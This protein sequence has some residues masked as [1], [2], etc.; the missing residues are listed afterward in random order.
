[1]R[2]VISRTVDRVLHTTSQVELPVDPEAAAFHASV[3]VVDLVV[4][5]PLFRTDLLRRR[6]HGHVDLPR[7][8]DGGVDLV[9]FTI[10]TRHPD[11]RGTLSTPH[12]WSLG[13]PIAT[14][15]NDVA[16][17]EAFS[18]R[19]QD[20]AARS[21]GRLWMVRSSVDLARVTS[22]RGVAAFI[23]IQGGHV[24][25][26][27]ADNVERLQRLGVRMFAPAH[28]MDGPLVGSNT[29]ARRG[30]LTGFGREVLVEL[31][32]LG[33]LVDLAHMSTRGIRDALPLLHRPFVLSH[34][35]FMRTSRAE[36][37][38]PFRRF[39][40]ARRNLPD[41]E[42]R[43]VA[44]AGGVVGLALSTRLLG[45]DDLDAVRRAF[46]AGLELCGPDRLALGSDLDGGFRAICDARGLP[47]ITGHLSAG[48]HDRATLTGFLG[49][50]AL[51][52]LRA[53][54]G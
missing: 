11:L 15:R 34:T 49:G 6:R 28:V 45:G 52:V 10:A 41:R 40:P 48:G 27:D 25:A 42:A 26:G 24:L 47:A 20:W 4:G 9:G 46:D 7:L 12:F 53:A 22:G 18:D 39:T 33:I 37:R 21:G 2:S 16:I 35:G 32:R 17:V 50:N 3:P 1:M 38:L 8:V 19:I 51:R 14:L 31:Q 54:A 5:T 36:S 44:E 29:G 43:M 13:L 30:G 23:G